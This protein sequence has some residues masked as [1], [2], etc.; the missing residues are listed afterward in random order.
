MNEA[1]ILAAT[2]G[3]TEISQALLDASFDKVCA[4]TAC[5]LAGGGCIS[6]V[7]D[8]VGVAPAGSAGRVARRG[9]MSVEG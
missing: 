9:F 5:V 8:R 6:G 3:K 2:E 1:A 4:C 7:V